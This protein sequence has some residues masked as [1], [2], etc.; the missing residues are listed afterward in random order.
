MAQLFRPG[1]NSLAVS[2]VGVVLLAPVAAIGLTFAY[3]ES[4][5]ATGQF[6]TPRQPVPFS[7][8]HHVGQLGLDCRY[9]HT[10][11]E[12]TAFAG[13]LSA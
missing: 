2:I 12:A 10:T 7:H 8:E 9:C 1:G 13:V 11:V 5:Y 3:W 4:P 6:V